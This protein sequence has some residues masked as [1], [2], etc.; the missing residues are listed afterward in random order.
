MAEG[1]EQQVLDNLNKSQRILIALPQNPGGDAV[2]AGLGLHNF[3]KK[4]EKQPEIISAAKSLENYLFLPGVKEIKSTLDISQSFV[5]SVGT[6]AAPLSELSYQQDDNRVDIFLKSKSGKYSAADV[7]FKNAKSPFDLIVTLDA[8][9]LESLG[10]VYDNNTD[11]FFETPILNVDHHPGNEHYGQINLVD[12][13]ATSTSEILAVLMENFEASLVDGDIATNLL[14]GIIAETNSFQHAKTTPKAFLKAS[15]LIVQGANQPE[16]I[17]HL[18]KTKHVSL[19]KL[20]GRALARI[21]ELPELGLTYSM[22]NRLDLEKSGSGPED[23]SSVM[24]EL[25]ANLSEKKM[26]LFLAEPKEKEIVGYFHLHP[27]IRSQIVA[28]ALGGEMINGLLGSF[29]LTGVN[30]SDAEKQ[31]L[32]KLEKIKNQILV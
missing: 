25:V 9:S 28:A 5:I 14:A 19:L 32:E 26:I 22:V 7:T 6:S 12:L 15:N 30:L 2:G 21:K 8:P 24:K 16:I 3:L 4:L 10:D 23:I 11:L 13:T 29:H 31:T 20:W 18:Y 27:N 17:K 1:I